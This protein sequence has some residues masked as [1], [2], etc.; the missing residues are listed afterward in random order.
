[1]FLRGSARAHP[2]PPTGVWGL[3][4][5]GQ[6]WTIRGRDG[7]FGIEPGEPQEATS[8]LETDPDTLNASCLIRPASTKRSLKAR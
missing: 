6:V 2:D 3:V 8:Q 5:N 7:A 1:M 4:L